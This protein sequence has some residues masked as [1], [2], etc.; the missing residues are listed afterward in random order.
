MVLGN[1]R[2]RAANADTPAARCMA[3][4]TALGLRR[5]I[6]SRC[7]ANADGERDNAVYVKP[8]YDAFHSLVL[9]RPRSWAY[10]RSAP[11]P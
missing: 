9:S 8:E 11:S 10:L 4:L 5:E 6:H 1:A 2:M 7:R 3:A